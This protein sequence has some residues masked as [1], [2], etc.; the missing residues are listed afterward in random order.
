MIQK[1]TDLFAIAPF[2]C[3]IESAW[4]PAVVMDGREEKIEKEPNVQQV[5][6]EVGIK[7]E[8]ADPIPVG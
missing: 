3:E 6:F 1:L 4:T 5:R 2:G 8:L 7:V